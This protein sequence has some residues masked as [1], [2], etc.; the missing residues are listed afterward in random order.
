MDRPPVPR[1]F[2]KQLVVAASDQRLPH[3]CQPVIGDEATAYRE[4]PHGGVE[5]RD[6]HGRGFDK[7]LKLRLAVAQDRLGLPSRRGVADNDTKMTRAAGVK[8]TDREVDRKSRAVA[9]DGE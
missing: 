7:H 1:E 5:H 3:R 9:P 4:I 8:G 2:G 6:R